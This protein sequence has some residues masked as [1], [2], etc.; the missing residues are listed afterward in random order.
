MCHLVPP[1][2]GKYENCHEV[3]VPKT[4]SYNGNVHVKGNLSGLKLNDTV[5]VNLRRNNDKT[6]VQTDKYQYR[7]GEKVQLRILTITGNKMEVSTEGVSAGPLAGRALPTSLQTGGTY[8]PGSIPLS[9]TSPPSVPPHAPS[10]TLRSTQHLVS[11]PTS[12]TIP[13]Y[14]AK[15]RASFT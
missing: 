10:L 2:A 11:V 13:P 14:S 12:G 7:P 8:P 4:E 9:A 1:S 5:G 3:V 6:F 15:T